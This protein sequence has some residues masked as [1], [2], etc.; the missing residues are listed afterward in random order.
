MDTAKE[1]LFVS[2]AYA[3]Y[4]VGVFL[5]AMFGGLVWMLLAAQFGGVLDQVAS[6]A[7][8]APDTAV[9]AGVSVTMIGFFVGNLIGALVAVKVVPTPNRSFLAAMGGRSTPVTDD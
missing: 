2:V 6:R 4:C 9:I 5:W 3:G 7:E 1:M 8:L